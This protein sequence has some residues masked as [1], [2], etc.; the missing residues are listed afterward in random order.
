[1]AG[2]L[3]LTVGWEFNWGS[4]RV[5]S[6]FHVASPLGCLGFLNSM[7]AGFQEQVFQKKEVEAAS[8]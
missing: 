1:M 6:S 8:I 2:K 3:V 7:A 4:T 5:L